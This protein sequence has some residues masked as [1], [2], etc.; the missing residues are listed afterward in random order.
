MIDIYV[1][2]D[3]VNQQFR[4][5]RMIDELLDENQWDYRH[6]EIFSEPSHFPNFVEESCPQIFF[7]DIDIN[8]DN[9]RELKSLRKLGRNLEQLR[10]FLLRRI[11]SLCC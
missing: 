4:I 3:N 2:E 11:P 7:L 5:E 1:L 6:F 8:G 9:K 10:L